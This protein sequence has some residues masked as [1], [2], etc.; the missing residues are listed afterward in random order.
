MTE[1]VI[2]NL[3]K[4]PII[5]E[6][7][8]IELTPEILEKVGGE[9]SP[10]AVDNS[11]EINVYRIVYTSND[12]KVVGFIVEPKA[13]ENLPCVIYNRGGS[14][15]FGAIKIGQIFLGLS[16]FSRNGYITFMSQYSGNS[17]SEGVDEFGGADIDDVTN[18]YEI[19]K[20][21]PRA[22]SEKIGMYG[23][24][25]GGMMTYLALAKANWIKSAIVLSGTADLVNKVDFRDMEDH[26]LKMFGGGLEEKEKRSA[27]LWTEKFPKNCPILLLHGTA[28][29]RVNPKDSLRIAEKFLE[30]KIPYRLVMFEGGDH[31]LS[32]FKKE[33]SIMKI[34]WFDKYLKRNIELPNIEPHGN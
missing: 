34:D 2:E 32:E 26:Y 18:L 31:F 14:N 20:S 30:N 7:K 17:G 22:D 1:T 16:L 15:D 29:W 23:A 11:N 13:G 5:L 8:K 25:R 9:L 12:H 19:I 24:S 3:L 28:D 6:V 10:S 33:S 21:H 27:I 4:N